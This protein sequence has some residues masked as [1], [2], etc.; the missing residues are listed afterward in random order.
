MLIP[1]TYNNIPCYINTDFILDVFEKDGKYIAYTFDNERGGYAI[2]KT[3][4]DKF[5]KEVEE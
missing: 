5:L 2:K 3:V 4:F 1:A